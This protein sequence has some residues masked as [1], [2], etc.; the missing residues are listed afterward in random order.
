MAKLEPFT[1][2]DSFK[3][4]YSKSDKVYAKV[5]KFDNQ[6]IGIR[7]KNPATNEPPSAAQQTVQTTFKAIHAQVKN[8]LADAEQKAALRAE[9]Q[10]QRKC[11]SLTGYVFRKFYLQSLTQQNP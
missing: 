4:K 8:A 3:G 2:L 11:K 9:W 1:Y 10:Q 7:V 6:V 5:R